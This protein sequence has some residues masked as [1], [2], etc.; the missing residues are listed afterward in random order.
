[1]ALHGFGSQFYSSAINA[2]KL[3][4]GPQQ[5]NPRVLREIA[6]MYMQQKTRNLKEEGCFLHQKTPPHKLVQAVA[7]LDPL[8]PHLT[9]PLLIPK[10]A[11]TK[12]GPWS[13]SYTRRISRPK[14]LHG[15]KRP[16]SRIKKFS[17]MICHS[18]GARTK[19]TYV[20]ERIIV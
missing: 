10:V 20:L 2:K 5:W 18:F 3:E 12:M 17:A 11:A 1:M 9:V 6:P 14:K 7:S 4:T 15:R 8:P 16:W 13:R 19:I